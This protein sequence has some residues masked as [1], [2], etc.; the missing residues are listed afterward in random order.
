MSIKVEILRVA[1]DARGYV[2]E[3]FGAE[4]GQFRNVHVVYTV[5][6]V[7]RGNHYHVRGT[8]VC[9]VTGPTLVRYRIADEVGET[10]VP[11]GQ[12]WRFTFP[13]GVAHA[14]RNEGSQP[15]LIAAFN[16]EEHDPDRPDA[17]RAVLIE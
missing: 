16:T 10:L 14:F 6:G 8:E 2:F 12:V 13:P 5:P 3:P 7:V 4:L 9:S 1:Q 15:V 11:A 17:V